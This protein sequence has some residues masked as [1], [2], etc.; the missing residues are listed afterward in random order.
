MDSRD[1]IKAIDTLPAL[2]IDVDPRMRG[3]ILQGYE[4]S[5]TAARKRA[6]VRPF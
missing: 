1:D 2:Q 5:K 3:A 6:S 4:A